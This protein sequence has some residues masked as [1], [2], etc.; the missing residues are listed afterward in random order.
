MCE[1]APHLP[2][3]HLAVVGVGVVVPLLQTPDTRPRLRNEDLEKQRT[4]LEHLYFQRDLLDFDM[5]R[6]IHVDTLKEQNI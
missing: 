6:R 2:G 5:M 4:I 3:G 1:D